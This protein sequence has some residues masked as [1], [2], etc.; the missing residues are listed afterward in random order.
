MGR[1]H[2][3]NF[4]QEKSGLVR[5]PDH[6]AGPKRLVNGSPLV[7]LLHSCHNSNYAH[8]TYLAQQRMKTAGHLS[9][10]KLVTH[11]SYSQH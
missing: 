5:T 6:W 8:S 9:H 11:P 2:R 10:Q 4:F 7:S 3:Y 1:E